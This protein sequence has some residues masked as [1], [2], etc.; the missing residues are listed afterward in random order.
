MNNK[1]NLSLNAWNIIIILISV[2]ASFKIPIELS[3]EYKYEQHDFVNLLI[4]LVFLTD[5]ILNINRL[6]KIKRKEICDDFKDSRWFQ[7]ILFLTNLISAVPWLLIDSIPALNLLVLFKLLRVF[8][9]LR[10]YQQK[11][12]QFTGVYI[13]FSFVFWFTLAING[14]A[15]GWHGLSQQILE[16]D[17]STNYI[18]A[19]YWTITTLTS[20]GYGDIIPISN[21]QKIFAI[22]VQVLGF[23]VFSFFIG[24]VASRLMR[25][26][27]A[28]LKYEENIENLASLMHY[29]T[30]PNELRN[31]IVNFYSHMW[32]KRLG[33]DETVF[34]QSLPKNLQTEVA[35]YLKKEVI[36][37][38]SIFK[39]ASSNFKREIALL[40]RPIFL[41]PGDYIFKAGDEGHEMY[42]VVNGELHTLTHSED[43]VLTHLL[44]GDFFGEIALFKNQNRSAT[45]KAI[46]YCDIYI[47]DKPSFDK[48]ISKYP[49][50]GDKIKTIVEYRESK[51]S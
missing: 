24:T 23:G 33:Y 32:R 46:S 19:L 28:R 31:K 20:V 48:V 14:L 35:L 50:V 3:F 18:N 45:V 25:K 34:L 27:P 2:Y 5:L 21:T 43:R 13:F 44:P 39:N 1:Y 30:L 16:I 10:N 36:E 12:V 8:D 37:K 15:C 6:K 22:F 41:T 40:L 4:S 26:D 47:L 11:T 49:D 29:R 17:F 9:I 51:Y 7:S 42:F 38:V